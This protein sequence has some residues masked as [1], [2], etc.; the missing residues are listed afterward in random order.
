MTDQNG[1]QAALNGLVDDCYPDGWPWEANDVLRITLKDGRVYGAAVLDING[2]DDTIRINM[3]W[4]TEGKMYIHPSNKYPLAGTW[5]EG[6]L[7]E[8]M[9]EAFVRMENFGES[10]H[11]WVYVNNREYPM[12]FTSNMTPNPIQALIAALREL[13][14][15]EVTNGE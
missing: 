8:E 2:P 10:Y 15:K 9:G 6:R 11:V 5:V 3:P 1:D 7:R 12:R 13:K 4:A 14:Q